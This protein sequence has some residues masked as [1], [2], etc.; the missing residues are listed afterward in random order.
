MGVSEVSHEKT[1]TQL[2]TFSLTPPNEGSMSLQTTCNNLAVSN[3]P[4][5]VP[6]TDDVQLMH[7]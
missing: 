7:G 3:L 6:M 4:H 2:Q 1:G 5:W